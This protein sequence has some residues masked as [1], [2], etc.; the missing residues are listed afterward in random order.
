M[1]NL[2]DQD[3]LLLKH[4]RLHE[5]AESGA[6][7]LL[8]LAY[9]LLLTRWDPLMSCTPLPKAAK[10]VWAKQLTRLPCL[11]VNVK[12]QLGGNLFVAETG[13]CLWAAHKHLVFTDIIVV[14]MQRQ[15][16]G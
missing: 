8:T 2:T 10:P 3:E 13:V 4:Q 11:V 7:A 14:E 16:R 9:S 6:L 15:N 5:R 12:F 1:D